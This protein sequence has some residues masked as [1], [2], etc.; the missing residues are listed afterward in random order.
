MIYINR[1]QRVTHRTTLQVV[2]NNI[3]TYLKHLFK[4][5]RKL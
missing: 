4:N 5:K 2:P 3:E 1:K